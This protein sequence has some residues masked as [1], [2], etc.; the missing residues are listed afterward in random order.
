MRHISLRAPAVF[1]LLLAHMAVAGTPNRV[2]ILYDSFGKS[3]TL[4]MD[5][6]FAALVDYGGK[7]ILF[8]TGNN[9]QIFEH[10]VKAAGVDLQKLDFV[11]MSHRHGDHMGG[12]AYLLKVNPTVKI[13]APKERSGVYGDDQPSS[14][15]YRN[16]PSLPAE[17]R[18]YSGAPPEVIHMGEAWPSANFQLIDKNVEIVPGMYLI[19]LV[20]DKP[21]TLELRELS[22]AIRTPDGLLLVVGCSHPGVEHILQ[23][24]SAID[25]HINLLLGGLHQIQAPDPEVERIAK[26]LHDQYK[27]DR[28]APGHCTGE[29]EFAALKKTFGDHYV[30]AGVGSVVDLPK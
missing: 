26:V 21:G 12:L 17:Q 29:P 13:Y 7:R 4:T 22:L 15:W 28:I 9:A 16:D 5:W 3:P 14:T 10:N 20:S 19:A 11:V 6:G 8:D 1:I 23:E 30:Y 2:T 18:Y 27:L 25:P 24:A